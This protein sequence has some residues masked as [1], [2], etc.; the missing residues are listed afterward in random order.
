ME[1]QESIDQ[2]I[3]R[4][5]PKELRFCQLYAQCLNGARAAREAGYS[6]DYAREIACQNLA[7][8]H[9][10]RVVRHFLEKEAMPVEE[11]VKRLS[12][13]GRGSFDPFLT[14]SGSLDIDSDTAR[15]NIGLIKKIKQIK[16][17]EVGK[18]EDDESYEITSTEIELH[19]AKDAL[20]IL[21][22]V[23][24]KLVQKHEVYIPPVVEL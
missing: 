14:V 13:M 22:E 5:T 10:K 20:K 15:E 6:K 9:I 11:A 19:D 16:R 23:H 1:E 12:D 2:T 7:K 21:L 18:R 3:E 17:V 24:G 4:L 8:L